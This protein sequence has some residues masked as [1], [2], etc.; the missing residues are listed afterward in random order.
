MKLTLARPEHAKRISHFYASVHDQSFPHQ[1]L[2]SPETLATLLRQQELAIVIAVHE[3]SIL[4]CG[5][6]FVTHWNEALEIGAI[7]VAPEAPGGDVSRALFEALRR[8][9]MKSYGVVYFRATGKKGFQRGR[10]VGASCWGYRP[11]PGSS[12][13]GDAELIMGFP[14]PKG[15]K[16]RAEPPHNTITSSPFA[17][18]II[19]SIDDSQ[20]GIPYPK[21][22][23]V[24]CP[25]GT[26]A[27]VISGRIWPTYHSRGNFIN[28]ENAAG[29]YP[30]EII[31]EFQKKVQKK[32]VTDIRLTLPVNQ[33][34]AYFELMGYGFRPVAYLPGWF[35]R[36]AHRFDCIQMVS[37]GPTIPRQ[38]QGFT[39]RAVAR[40]D[41]ELNVQ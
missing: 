36:G 37:G 31:K 11:L 26:G 8:L 23:P 9:G 41:E 18:R 29:A 15:H 5:L 10:K 28:I 14:H 24:G 6:A 38:P 22:Y 20:H 34:E 39:E 25:Q 12:S 30:V 7:S 35:L 40:I 17:A 19:A 16:Q 13:A 4:G 1:E 33:E 2:F 27:P 3:R 32:G 21:S